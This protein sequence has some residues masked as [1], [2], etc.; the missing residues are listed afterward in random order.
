MRIIGAFVPI[1]LGL[2]IIVSAMVSCTVGQAETS[3]DT[4]TYA[5]DIITPPETLETEAGTLSDITAES[6]VELSP[7]TLAEDTKAQKLKSV[8]SLIFKAVHNDGLFEDIIVYPDKLAEETLDVMMPCRVDLTRVVFCAENLRGD[9]MGPYLADFSDDAVSDNEKFY[10][11]SISKTIRLLQS[12]LPSMMVSLDGEHGRIEDVMASKNHSVSAYGDMCVTVTD[13]V[14]REKGWM[15]V[16]ASEEKDSALYGTMSIKGRGNA[17]WR[18]FDKK[19]FRI[20]TEKKVGLLGMSAAKKWELLANSLDASLL[21]NQIFYDLALDMGLYGTECR[22]VDL[23]VNGRY[24]GVYLLT[25]HVEIDETGGYLIEIDNYYYKEVRTFKTKRAGLNFT[26]NTQNVPGG[27]AAVEAKLNEIEAAIYN[28]SDDRVFGMLDIESFAKYYILQELSLNYDVLQGSGYMYYIYSDG[29]L[30]AG[31]AW[32]MDNTMAV[33][34]K[35]AHMYTNRVYAAHESWFK[36]L[37]RNE[38]FAKEVIRQYFECGVREEILALP[39]KLNEY[40]DE[41]SASARVNHKINSIYR[42]DNSKGEYWDDDVAYLNKRLGERIEW[43]ERF[44]ADYRDANG[45]F[46]TIL[47]HSIP[48]G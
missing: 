13:E 27:V 32:D 25:E 31:P 12:S 42:H 33:F 30:Y 6:P 3:G 46:S 16:Y 40:A 39:E 43:L 47:F 26:V 10:L 8:K 29:K 44:M 15:T 36:M 20:N 41:I 7:T 19:P 1:I 37:L 11:G 5:S 2:S 22:Q 24:F 9:I 17:T 4:S 38:T 18:D 21:R 14:A 28:T 34:S 45:K 35:G 48:R 23:F